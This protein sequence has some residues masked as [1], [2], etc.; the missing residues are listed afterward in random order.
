MGGQAAS[1]PSDNSRGNLRRMRAARLAM[2]LRVGIHE[3][4]SASNR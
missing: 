4:N 3:P 2:W 1:S